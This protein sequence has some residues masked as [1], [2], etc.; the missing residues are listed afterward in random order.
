MPSKKKKRDKSQQKRS[1]ARRVPLSDTPS[2]MNRLMG[3]AHGIPFQM[4]VFAAGFAVVMSR[5]PDAIWNAQF[6]AEDGMIWYSHAYQFGWR[7]VLIPQAGYLQT[8]SRT[9]A[10]LS[11]LFPFSLAPLVMNVSAIVVQILPVNVFLSS[12]FSQVPLLTRFVGGFIFLAIPNSHEINA[13]ITNVQWHLALL[14][15]LLLLAQTSGNRGWRVFDAIVLLFTSFSSPIGMLLIPVAALL[16]WK[17]RQVQSAWSLG[18]LIPGAITESL[19]ALLGNERPPT[20]N[21]ASLC[22]LVRILGGQVYFSAIAGWKSQYFLLQQQD[23][24]RLMTAANSCLTDGLF[25]ASL[26]AAAIGLTMAVYALIYAPFEVKLFLVFCF[27]VLA[28]SLARPLAGPWQKFTQWGYLCFPGRASRY[29][30]FPM[31]GF[32]TSLVWVATNRPSQTV[33][34]YLA[35]AVLVCMPFGIYEDWSYPPFED[36]HFS[37]YAA[38]FER[39]PAGTQFSLPINPDMTMKITKK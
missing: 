32:L 19:V 34:R 14:A 37:W 3:F 28:L 39:A 26:I 2:A 16:W 22:R 31:L 23:L 38:E 11:L 6:Y 30:F 29:Y 36:F 24:V 17:R 33:F 8:L 15:C 9:V 25:Y 18:L 1:K 35:I 12:R 5:R 21:G 4:V 27:L 7:S 13:N 20:A 10:L